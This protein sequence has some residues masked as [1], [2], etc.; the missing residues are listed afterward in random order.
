MRYIGQCDAQLYSLSQQLKCQVDCRKRR[1]GF[2]LT[3]WEQIQLAALIWALME[4]PLRMTGHIKNDRSWE[5]HDEKNDVEFVFYTLIA[6]KT[7]IGM[8]TGDSQMGSWVRNNGS[9]RGSPAWKQI[10]V[11]N[12]ISNGQGLKTH[13]GPKHGYRGIPCIY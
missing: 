13:Q 1:P 8:K 6:N 11:V 4:R 3:R 12:D 10:L 7:N 5:T 9:R 2:L